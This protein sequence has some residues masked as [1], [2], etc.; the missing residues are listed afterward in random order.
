M[1]TLWKIQF[2]PP[3]IAPARLTVLVRVDGLAIATCERN[4]WSEIPDIQD[5][6]AQEALTSENMLTV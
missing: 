5:L 6:C 1:T 4:R 3:R 2:G